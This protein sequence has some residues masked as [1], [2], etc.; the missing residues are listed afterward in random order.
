MKRNRIF[1]L[2]IIA[3]SVLPLANLMAHGGHKHDP[4]VTLPIGVNDFSSYHPLIV[5]FPIVLLIVAAIIQIIALFSEQKILHFLVAGITIA[6]F[7]GAYVAS[8]I[9]HPH[10]VPLS[11]SATELLE[12]HEQYASYTIWLSGFASLLKLLSLFKKKKVIEIIVA[13]L[14]LATAITVSIAG[15][16]GAGLTHKFGIGPKG[17]YLESNHNH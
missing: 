5:H 11:P 9:V 13:V 1:Y 7:I 17:N 10:T 4:N 8:T 6:G 14:L 16:H 2:F 3:F 15:H 12:S